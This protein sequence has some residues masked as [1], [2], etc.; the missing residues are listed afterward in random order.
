MCGILILVFCTASLLIYDG[1]GKEVK[2]MMM[3][4]FE[5]CQYR[6]IIL[7]IMEQLVEING[8]I[9]VIVK[10]K[11]QIYGIRVA[12]FAGTNLIKSY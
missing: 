6:I 8:E 3:S 10:S 4:L 7:K 11:P 12:I 9:S 2:E 5:H 1:C